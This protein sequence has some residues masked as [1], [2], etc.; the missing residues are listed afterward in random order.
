MTALALGIALWLGL[1]AAPAAAA[2]APG[3]MTWGIHVTVASGWFDPAETAGLATPYLVLYA[4][5]DALVKP[6]PGD[7]NA[8]CLA[9][10]W[11][12][13][14]DGLAYEFVLRKGAT[15]HNGDPVTAEDVKF[16]FERYKGAGA[17][18]YRD[19]VAA[20]EILGPQ[21]V[22]FRLK[23]P[24][25]DFMTFY[26]TSATG[27]GWIVPKKYVERVGPDAFKTAPV[28][29]GPYKVAS[30]TPGHEIVLEAFDGYWRKPPAVKRLVLRSMPEEATR[31]AALKAG[32]VDFAFNLRGPI[33]A[34]TKTT[35]GLRL[36]AEVVNAVFWLELPDQWD[37]R[38]PVPPAASFPAT[39]SS[40]SPSRRRRSIHREPGSCSRRPAT[41]T[42]STPA[43]SI[44]SPLW[45]PAARPWR[46]TCKPSA[47]APGCGRSSVRPS[48]SPGGRT[49]FEGSSWAPRRPPA[50][51]PPAWRPS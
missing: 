20:V 5:H 27:A 35:P 21:R 18:I 29:A 41:R 26:G 16:S 24:W 38:S 44:R 32:D 10:S 36:E 25:P 12:L 22:R 9:E 7:V 40:R 15:F 1:G 30:F 42:A 2:S 39:S 13:S 4:V 19:K 6:M 50:T 34:S 49:S 3:T 23:E 33:A 48:C 51:P 46:A 47:S 37:P 31:F 11:S 28:G 14:K 45:S 43:T 17:K 8:P